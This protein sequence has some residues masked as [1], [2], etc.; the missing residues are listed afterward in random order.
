MALD[1]PRSRPI[2]TLFGGGVRGKLLKIE[3]S[4]DGVHTGDSLAAPGFAGGS[5]QIG[6]DRPYPRQSR[7]LPALMVGFH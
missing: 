5:T 2:D 3:K 1:F 4:G 7:G 6:V